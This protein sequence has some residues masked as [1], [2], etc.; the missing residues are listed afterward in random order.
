[1]DTARRNDNIRR[2]KQDAAPSKSTNQ[3][4]DPKPTTI[5]PKYSSID[6]SPPNNNDH[7]V[8]SKN[9]GKKRGNRRE[10]R[11]HNKDSRAEIPNK[12]KE[13]KRSDRRQRG[14]KRG[15]ERNNRRNDN[16]RMKIN[17]NDD[18]ALFGFLGE[19]L[20]NSCTEQAL[21]DSSYSFIALI[22][23]LSSFSEEKRNRCLNNIAKIYS[24]DSVIYDT[25]LERKTTNFEIILKKVMHLSQS[26]GSSY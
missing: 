2:E 10:K 19:T 6:K 23:K 25:N 17:F 4:S 15:R 5:E 21:Y 1:M 12:E 11:G 24:K 3:A 8:P 26:L 20:S 16:K 9:D 7:P 22:S 13:Y 18:D 14:E